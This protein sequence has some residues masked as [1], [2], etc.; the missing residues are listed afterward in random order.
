[1]TYRR[2]R[3]ISLIIAIVAVGMLVLAF[4]TSKGGRTRVGTVVAADFPQFYVAAGILSDPGPGR[5]YDLALQSHRQVVLFPGEDRALPYAYPPIVAYLFR[6]FTYFSYT[7]A[8]GIFV[9]YVAMFY[10]IGVMAL[11]W[12]ARIFLCAGG[13]WG[14]WFVW[15][16]SRLRLSVCM[17]V[18]FRRLRL[19]V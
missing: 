10:T 2:V 8:A 9:A 4:A 16:L 18:R 3:G 19:L 14:V 12:R 13:G 1:M 7:T 15:R 5:L 11:F 6:P 17:G